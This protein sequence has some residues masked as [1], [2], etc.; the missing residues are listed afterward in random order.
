MKIYGY[1][2]LLFCIAGLNSIKA[3]TVEEWRGVNRDGIYNETNLLKK[4]PAEGPKMLWHF[5]ELGKGYSSPIIT[6]D[7][8][9]V[10]GAINGKGFVF[11]LDFTGKKIWGTEYGP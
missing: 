11:A 2:I 5:D 6:K 1:I 3:Q 4:W 7:R 10:T 9:Y 8:I